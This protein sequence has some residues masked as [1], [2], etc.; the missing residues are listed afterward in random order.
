MNAMEM[1]QMVVQAMW[2]R[3]SPLKQIPHFGPEVVQVANDYKYV[4]SRPTILTTVANQSFCSINDIFEFMEAMDPSENKD[5]GSLVKRLGLDNKQL[6]QAAA[7]TND[8]YPN[9]DLDFQVE[10]PEN[11]TSGEPANLKVKIERE[12]E[13]DEEPDTAVHSPFYP[14]R[15]MENWWLVVGEEK[16][17][18]LLAIKRITIGRKLDLR[19]EYVV[20][21][22]G[23]HE[24]TLYLM[25][26]SYVGVDQAPTFTVTAAEGMEEDESEEEEEE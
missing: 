13:E 16:T 18:N 7:F 14:N 21:E 8:K 19:L 3:D 11:V 1:S 6:A 10:D 12:V 23:E 17:K 5:Y 22:P 4:P 25:S 26:D 9:I 15:K 24:L 20:P 2:D